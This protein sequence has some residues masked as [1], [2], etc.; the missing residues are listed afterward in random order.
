MHVCLPDESIYK[1]QY[2]YLG[3]TFQ[4]E[5]VF[6]AL[7]SIAL[8]RKLVFHLYHFIGISPYVIMSV[9]FTRMGTLF[10]HG[11]FHSTSI[12]SFI[13]STILLGAIFSDMG[14]IISVIEL[15]CMSEY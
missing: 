4:F 12:C 7:Y 15:V 3:C 13:F 5:M 2:I 11:C 6:Y 8:L 10:W 14:Q 9:F 1:S